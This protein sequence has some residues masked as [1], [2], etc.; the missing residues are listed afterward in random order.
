MFY[1]VT[2]WGRKTEKIKSGF[3]DIDYETYCTKKAERI[4][5]KGRE[6]KVECVGNRC[7]VTVKSIT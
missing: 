5:N 1:E 7:R 6:S 3:G 4:N 2:E